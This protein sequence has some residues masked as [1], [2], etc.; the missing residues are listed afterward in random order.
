MNIFRISHRIP[1][2][3]AVASTVLLLS[4]CGGSDEE[5]RLGQVNDSSSQASVGASV[6]S[7]SSSALSSSTSSQ[8]SSSSSSAGGVGV[9]SSLASSRSSTSSIN[10]TSSARSSSSSSAAPVSGDVVIEWYIP[11]ERE[12]GDY[13]ELYEIGGYEIRYKLTS[14]EDYQSVVIDD[15]TVDHYDLGE[16]SGDYEFQIATFDVN[17]LYSEFVSISPN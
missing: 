3:L 14:T 5:S 1:G 4:A 13:L 15:G 2:L 9:S 11:T 7:N 16:L 6:P 17:G 8:R 10:S 12:N